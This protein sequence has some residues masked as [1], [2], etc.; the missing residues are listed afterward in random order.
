MPLCAIEVA[1]SV[2]VFQPVARQVAGLELLVAEIGLS[3]L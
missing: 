3:G 1:G 2:S